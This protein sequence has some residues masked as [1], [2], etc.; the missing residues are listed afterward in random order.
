[1]FIDSTVRLNLIKFPNEFWNA[2]Q[3]WD[4]GKKDRGRWFLV[5]ASHCV[6]LVAWND[7]ATATQEEFFK[8]T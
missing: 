2:L 6:S 4:A 8:V 1:M 3:R 7:T 5:S